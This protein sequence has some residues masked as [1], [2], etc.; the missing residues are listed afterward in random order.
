MLQKLYFNKKFSV[1]EKFTFNIGLPFCRIFE[2][3]QKICCSIVK[4]YIERK[5]KIQYEF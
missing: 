5:E 4:Y 3:W 1:Y 2:P